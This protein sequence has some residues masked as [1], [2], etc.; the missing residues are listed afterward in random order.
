M[1]LEANNSTTINF[2]FP[3]GVTFSILG[4]LV[5]EGSNQGTCHKIPLFHVIKLVDKT[6]C[7]KNDMWRIAKA[8]VSEPR[9]DHNTA[10]FG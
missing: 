1:H 3:G 4:A 6:S 9:K 8:S 10:M 7:I 2:H 5:L